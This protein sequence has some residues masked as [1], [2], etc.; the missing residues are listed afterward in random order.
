MAVYGTKRGSN[1]RKPTGKIHAHKPGHYRV[2]LCGVMAPTRMTDPV[3][4][5]AP[6]CTTCARIKKQLRF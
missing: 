5:P 4:E 2:P 3:F 6:T 1:V